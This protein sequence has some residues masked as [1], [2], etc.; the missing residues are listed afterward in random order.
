MHHDEPAEM[1]VDDGLGELGA[2]SAP[3]FLRL[4]RRRRV[5]R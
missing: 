2:L 1:G 5:S 4:K 3:G